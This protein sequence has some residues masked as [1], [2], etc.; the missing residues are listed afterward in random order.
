MTTPEPAFLDSNVLFSAAHRPTTV[1]HRLWTFPDLQ[2]L[3]SQYA[4]QEVERSLDPAR[5]PALRRLLEAVSEVPTPAPGARPLP[6]GLVLPA[7]D[8]PI[9]LATAA[10]GAGL[11]LTGDR[12]HFGPFFDQRFD[13][14]LIVDVAAFLRSRA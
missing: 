11:L 6:S 5:L 3:T 8:E 7:K 1:L 13:G 4:V 2:L 14:V 12:R 10:A 9:F